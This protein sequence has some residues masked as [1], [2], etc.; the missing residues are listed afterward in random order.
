MFKTLKFIVIKSIPTSAQY[1]TLHIKI[2]WKKTNIKELITKF[3]TH[4]EWTRK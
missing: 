4:V 3:Y 2:R 1:V